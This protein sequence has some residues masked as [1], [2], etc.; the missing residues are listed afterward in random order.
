MVR[1]GAAGPATR[2]DGERVSRGGGSGHWM[3]MSTHIRRGIASG[4]IGL[5][6]A[7]GTPA[8]VLQDGNPILA[9]GDTAETEDIVERRDEVSADGDAD[10]DDRGVDDVREDFG[11]DADGDG[12]A[13]A[14]ADDGCTPGLSVPQV[15]APNAAGY[16]ERPVALRSGSGFVSFVRLPGPAVADGLRFQRFDLG[17]VALDPAV[18]TIGGAELAPQHPLVEL[19]DGQF[20]PAFT[21]PSGSQPGIWVKLVRSSGTG[22]EVP[23]QVP[24]TDVDSSSPAITFDGVDVIVAWVQDLAG[25]VEIRAQH[26]D[27]GTGEPLGSYAVVASGPTGTGEPRIA[28]GDTRHALAYFNA[29]D[30]ALHVLSIDGSLSIVREDVLPPP[31]GES[32]VGYPALAWSGLEFGVAWETRGTSSATIHLAT[33]LQ[34]QAP[35]EHVPLEGVIALSAAELGQLALAWGE[36]GNEWGLAWRH[37]HAGRTGISLV[38]IDATDFHVKDGPIDVRPEAAAASN[39]SIA[40]NDGFYMITWVEDVSGSLPIYEA[41]YGCAP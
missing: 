6:A 16:E 9:G 29:A 35:V 7:L 20:A 37:S 13:D 23:R 18:W 4:V 21:V 1:M 14:E 25:T 10:A 34:D 26:L 36:V 11:A 33:F 32:F 22:V 12:H 31:S 2:P 41:T 30:G 19:A 40:H 3:C 5:L 17:G 15:V 39:P 28:W 8:C 38:R 24:D 27:S